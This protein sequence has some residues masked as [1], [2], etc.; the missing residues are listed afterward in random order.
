MLLWHGRAAEGRRY[1]KA[2]ELFKRE[3]FGVDEPLGR[4]VDYFKAAAAGSDVGRRLLLLL[5]PPSGGKSTLAILLKRGLEEYSRTEEGALY[6][7]KGSPLR[8]SPLNL[9]PTSLRAEFR[10]TY[11]VEHQRAKSAPGPAI[12]SIA[13]ARAIICACRWSGFSC[14][15]RR[16]AASAPTRRTIPRPPISPIWSDR[17]TFRRSRAWA[18]K[19]IRAPGP[20]R[21]PSMRRAAAC[22]R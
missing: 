21:A 6:A 5:G 8:E 18:M 15:R 10:E 22:S 9:I 7:I 17:S 11:G 12:I 16:A 3:L 4:V 1:Q 19:A 13:S 14:R 2:R 20:G